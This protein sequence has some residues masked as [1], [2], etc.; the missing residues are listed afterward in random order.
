MKNMNIEHEH[1]HE[2][3]VEVVIGVPATKSISQERETGNGDHGAFSAPIRMAPRN[4]KLRR[5]SRGTPSMSKSSA[6]LWA[7]VRI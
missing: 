7:G 2:C 4:A 3:E 6:H 5:R 1:E